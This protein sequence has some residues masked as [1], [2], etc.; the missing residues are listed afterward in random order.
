[1]RIMIIC[2]ILYSITQISLIEEITPD[3][4]M[5]VAKLKQDTIW[6]NQP[7]YQELASFLNLNSTISNQSY[8][9]KALECTNGMIF[10]IGDN[11]LEL[12]CAIISDF[13]PIGDIRDFSQETYHLITN[14]E[15]DKFIYFLS[16]IGMG[17]AVFIPAKTGVVILR[18]ARKSGNLTKPFLNY[19]L[20]TVEIQRFKQVKNLSDF[21]KLSV[22]LI[23]NKGI[24]DVLQ[25][26]YMIQKNSSITAAIQILKYVDNPTDLSKLVNLTKNFQEHTPLVL[27]ILGKQAIR[28]VRFSIKA[29]WQLAAILIGIFYGLIKLSIIGRWLAG[30]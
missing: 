15:V 16:I 28:I 10:G 30:R 21:K 18:S 8:F 3:F 17:S 13:T 6:Q 24:R 22:E 11:T 19:L 2:V 1:M 4:G 29:L 27:K 9:N 20:N 14:Q 23:N 5:I 12:G 26:I 25:N 7:E